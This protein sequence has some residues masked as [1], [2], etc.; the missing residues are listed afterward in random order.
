MK[1]EKIESIKLSLMRVIEIDNMEKDKSDF[2]V[3]SSIFLSLKDLGVINKE[4]DLQYVIT[5][6]YKTL[7]QK[8]LESRYSVD[9]VNYVGVWIKYDGEMF[10]NSIKITTLKDIEIYTTSKINAIFEF[11]KMTLPEL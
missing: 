3:R 11:V 6:M 7:L 4:E 5:D 2:I 8:T 10:E 1:V 9:P